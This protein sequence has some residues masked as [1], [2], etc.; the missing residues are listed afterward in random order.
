MTYLLTLQE[1]KGVLCVGTDQK[2]TDVSKQHGNSQ[3]V[4][5]VKYFFLI[6]K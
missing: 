4:S 2:N 3:S 1:S 6:L 5:R